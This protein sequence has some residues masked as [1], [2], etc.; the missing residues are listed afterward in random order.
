MNWEAELLDL[1]EKNKSEAGIVHYKEYKVKD[2]IEKYP[3]V[4]IPI[5]HTTVTAQIEVEIDED[6]NFL[7]ARTVDEGDKLTIIPITEKSGSRTAGKEPHPLCDNLQ[8]LAG[9]YLQYINNDGKET[10]EC[11]SQYIKL[12][13]K[14][15]FSKYTH[16]KVDAIYSYLTKK[17]L[18]KDLIQNDVL[19][20]DEKGFVDS[21]IK[22]QNAS[23]TKAFVRFVIRQ[24][25]TDQIT[26]DKCWVDRSLHKAYIEYYL[27]KQNSKEIDYLTG[28]IEQP[29]YL[30][31]K[32]IRNEGDGAKLISSNDETNYTFRG[33]FTSKEQ[34]FV[35]GS[36]T[37]QK[38]HNALK[39]IIRKQGRTYDTLTVV[40]WE[41]DML[42]MPLWDRDTEN[43]ITE[44]AADDMEEDLLQLTDD[45]AEQYQA[46]QFVEY[47]LNDVTAGQF[48]RALEGYRKKVKHTSR[49]ILMAFDAA[50]SGRLALME[51]KS[52][53]SA[54]YLDNIE[55][56]HRQCGWLQKKVKD[57]NTIEY[58]GVPGIRDIA[59]ILYGI[60][61]NGN[62]T[63]VDKNSKKLYAEIS[64]RLIPCIWDGQRLPYDLM[65]KS[66]EK[67]SS[68]QIYEKRYNWERVLALACSFVKKYRF[69]R[70]KEEWNMTV[71]Q[72][73]FDRSYLYGRLLAV[74][75]R[76]EY[77][78]YDWENNLRRITNAK[79]Y[80]ST[81]AQRPFTTWKVIEESIQPY[82]S[83][84]ASAQKNYYEEKLEDI[85]GKFS[86]AEFE[87][88]AKL[89][90][91]YLLGFHHESLDL[92]ENKKVEKKTN[93]MEEK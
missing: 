56:W 45:F 4:L 66:I 85:C 40:A 68:P 47:D 49:M 15:H 48:Y 82:L 79:R 10:E 26:E 36:E 41:S 63:I 32:K 78:T 16:K 50:T 86:V 84:M 67:A 27:S 54:R 55:K 12:L 9:D 1:Y 53:D 8:Y 33:R 17:S 44:S 93:D 21:T 65:Q 22:I 5:F 7:S 62:L 58:Y 64:K 52:M 87:N 2:K 51:Y 89:D 90:G 30:Q 75:D 29:S 18:M 72:K 57:K 59:D 24:N 46:E 80:M 61:S 39:W 43:L 3:Y 81:F 25:I 35:I 73:C 14:W 70:Y 92:H 20:L 34:A 42:K 77:V 76:I 38:V 83:K 69:D 11:F 6:G 37:S 13:E 91:L 23:Q 19:K 60:E 31:P 74:A 88:N 28:L 71:D